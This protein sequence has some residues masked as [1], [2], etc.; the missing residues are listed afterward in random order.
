M[1]YDLRAM[2]APV[3]QG[4]MAGGPATP[5]LAAA[6]TGAGGLGFLAGGYKAPDALRD[7]IASLRP[8]AGG[9]FGV[10]LFV[11]P[12]DRGEPAGLA[13]YRERIAREAQARG[14][15]TGDPVHSDDHWDA[16]LELLLADPVPVVSFTFGCPN[17]ETAEALQQRGSAVVVTVTTVD[18]A[19]RARDA[20]ADALCVQGA[21]AGGHQG[22]FDD[23]EQRTTPLLDLLSQV[24]AATELPLVGAGG[25]NSA[26]HTGA[27][28]RAGATAV[29]AGTAFLRAPESG[30]NPVHKAALADPAF[31]ETALTRA[32]SGRLARGLVNQ[33][34]RDH[35][36]AAPRAY[37][38][39]HYL[40]AP[41]RRDAVRSEDP[42]RV[43]LW[44][45]T[46]FR[47]ARQRPAA[48][49]VRQLT[50]RR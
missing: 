26:E 36:A 24:R 17:A 7:E 49:I 28:L 11:P 21:E 41:L 25:I 34:L 23:A 38:H 44:A 6:V 13:A 39:V 45:G 8:Q 5:R 30:A 32:F 22:S 15:T 12:P 42:D 1:R 10:N 29:Q 19:V 48:E 27:A 18:E 9:A 20:G 14:S 40:T 50:A 47:Q 43:N 33:F 4:P 31:A 2:T 16:K 35:T 37:P 3:V 46:G